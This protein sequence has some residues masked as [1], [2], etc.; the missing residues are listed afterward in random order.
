MQLDVSI[1]KALQFSMEDAVKPISLESKNGNVTSSI[2]PGEACTRVATNTVFRLGARAAITATRVGL[3][4]GFVPGLN[5]L[6]ETPFYTR[7]VYKLY[8]K[9]KFN[10][11][12]E[13]DYKRGVVRQSFTSANTV[14][15]AT[16]GAIL[17]QI[18]IPIPVLGGAVGG[19]LGLVAGGS[20]GSLEGWAASKL[21][22]DA[23]S[24]TLPVVV[25]HSFS[26]ML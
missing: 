19:A 17:G 24:V 8:R 13:A 18:A 25:I 23:K 1:H 10:Q 2:S 5:L 16:T 20:I 21:V 26:D 6:I 12:S 9:H 15:G 22:R 14:I 4:S 11:I 3:I 7:R